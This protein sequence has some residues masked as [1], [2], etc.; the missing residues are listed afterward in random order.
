MSYTL[1]YQRHKKNLRIGQLKKKKNINTYIETKSTALDDKCTKIE[2][3][4]NKDVEILREAIDNNKD[5]FTNR[6][7][8][9]FSQNDNYHKS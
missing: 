8:N 5:L 1:C 9:L 3:E 4:L 2:E 7:N 6:M